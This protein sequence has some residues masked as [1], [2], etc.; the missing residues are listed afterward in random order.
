[1]TKEDI[2]TRAMTRDGN[3]R[4]IIVNSTNT[5]N[6]AISRHGLTPTSAAALGRVLTAASMMG[7]LLKNKDDS[8]TITFN[9]DGVCGKVLACSDYMGNARGFIPNPSA[10]LPKNKLGKLDVSGAVGKNG[11]MYVIRDTGE[12]EPYIGFSPIVSGEIAE[13]ITNYFAKSEQIPTVCGLGVLI[14]T[15]YSCKAAGGFLIQL[16]PGADE[17]FISLLEQKMALLYSVSSL[18]SDGLSNEE[19]LKKLLTGIEFDIFD[20]LPV[21]YKCD[22]SRE[23]TDNALKLLGKKELSDMQKDETSELSCR[24]CGKKYIYTKDDIKNLIE[25]I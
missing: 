14:D 3:A 7:S 23:R 24:F 21:S 12:K 6:C 10:D 16:L 22:C 4:I 1:M 2:L 8:L 9:G 5:V 18:F 11:T 13:D 17:S 20:E 19:I 15:D 25:S